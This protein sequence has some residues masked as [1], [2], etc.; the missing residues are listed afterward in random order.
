MVAIAVPRH[1]Q[2]LASARVTYQVP[3]NMT[4]FP[5]WVPAPS[6]LN[7]SDDMLVW[8][9]ATLG[10]RR[11]AP[12]NSD[13]VRRAY[14]RVGTLRDAFSTTCG[15]HLTHSQ[16]YLSIVDASDRGV[17]SYLLASIHR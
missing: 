7:V 4:G 15:C 14:R 13:F 3:L 6:T 9:A 10:E 17:I 1:Q 16:N 12:R 5:N 2:R 11:R 8:A